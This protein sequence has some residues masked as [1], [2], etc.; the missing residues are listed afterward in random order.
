[1]IYTVYIDVVFAVNTIMDLMVLAVL[2]RVLSYRT[3]VWRLTA[4][5]ALG[6]L[7]SC[8]VAIYPGIPAGLRMFGTYVA[9]SSLMAVTAYGLRDIRDIAQSVAGIYLVSVVLGGMILFLR[10]NTGTGALVQRMFCGDGFRKIPAA[11]WILTAAGGAAACYGCFGEIRIFIEKMAEKRDICRVTLR[12][13]GREEQ[14]TGLIDTG[15]RL[16]EPATG[17]PVHVAEEKVLR[18]LCPEVKGVIYVPY[19]SIGKK[20]G[21]MPAFFMDEM[22]VEQE[23]KSYCIKKPLVAAS[24]NP[25]SPG[26]TYQILVQRTAEAGIRK[27][28]R[29]KKFAERIT[30]GYFHDHKSINTQSISAENGANIPHPSD[31]E[32]GGG[33]LYRGSRYSA[34]SSGSGR[35]GQ[36]DRT[37]GK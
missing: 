21:I 12:Y 9:V 30:G 23:G 13:G 22:E 34:G 2:N 24:E 18:R 11:A 37:S 19:C 36:D 14:V 15:N 33:P 3:T 35:R 7:W 10:E 26:G 1:M 28:K 16:F 29:R 25:L 20:H 6:G 8:V 32:A 5:A 27:G 31:A 17:R 4:G